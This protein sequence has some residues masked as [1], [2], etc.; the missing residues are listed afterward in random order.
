[1]MSLLREIVR[2]KRAWLVVIALLFL[3]TVVL[4]ILVDGSQAPRIAAARTNW[5]DLRRQA[6]LAGHADPAAAYGRN[7]DDLET[8]RGR[9]PPRRQFPRVLGEI[10]EQAASCGLNS[11]RISYQPR[12][13]A[14]QRLLAY[15]VSMSVSGRYAAVKNFLAELLGNRELVVVETLSL[16][17]ADF[18]EERV[19]MDLRLT[20]YLREDA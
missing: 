6:V 17:N 14:E 19:T 5:S 15:G 7:R 10:L 12:A 11:G 16:A 9:I 18:M 4:F 3:V 20:I 2:L 1:M 13:I 8:L